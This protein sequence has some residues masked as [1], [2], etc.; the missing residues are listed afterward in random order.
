MD[1]IGWDEQ[2]QLAVILLNT[3]YKN[4]YKFAVKCSNTIKERNML[5]CLLW[6]LREKGTSPTPMCSGGLSLPF[7]NCLH[8]WQWTDCSIR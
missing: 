4:A 2:G 8:R 6:T 5:S 1:I 7:F 3:E